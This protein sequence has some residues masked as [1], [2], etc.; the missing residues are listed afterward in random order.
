MEWT[1]DLPEESGHYWVRNDDERTIVE[2]DVLT[3]LVLDVD[4]WVDLDAFAMDWEF[5]GSEPIMEPV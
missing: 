3:R 5:W 4:T 1:T 2:V